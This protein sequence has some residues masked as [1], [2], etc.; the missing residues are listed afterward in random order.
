MRKEIRREGRRQ[1]AGRRPTPL[2]A[3]RVGVGEE[4]FGRADALFAEAQTRAARELAYNQVREAI[5]RGLVQGVPY[6]AR[7]L[8]GAGRINGRLV[9][10]F[11][12]LNPRMIDAVRELETRVIT[13][14]D[15]SIR[16]TV[17]AFVENGIRDGVNPRT[18]A[19]NLRAVIG[20]APNQ[21]TAIRN[22]ERALRG[23]NPNASPLDYQLRDRRFDRTLA[24]GEPLTEEQI[25]R[26]VTAYRK[27][28]IA[29]NAETNART[30]ALDTQ[31]LAQRLSFEDAIAK[32]IVSRDRMR[33]TWIGVMDD[34]ER[35]THRAMEGV[36]VGFDDVFVLP[37]GKRE[38][39]PGDGEF[40]CRCVARYS[41]DR[42]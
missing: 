24:K 23:E 26:M 28:M 14:L 18:V 36:T 1:V 40:N 3:P 37:D 9:V 41:Q 6:F 35:D 30:A 32:G 29:F 4:A 2:R 38:L 21:E 33:K 31:K 16:D 20:L 34:R 10:S 7:D 42:A 15:E 27:R 25:D 17:K 13:T 11:D 19:R 39:I 12:V 5:R 22:F 8:P